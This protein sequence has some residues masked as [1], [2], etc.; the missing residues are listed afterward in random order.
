[1]DIIALI[2]PLVEKI[3]EERK[4]LI[5]NPESLSEFETEVHKSFDEAARKFM[6]KTLEDLDKGI[7]EHNYRKAHYNIQR[8]DSRTLITTVGDVTFNRTL[9]MNRESGK[10]RYL[11]DDMLRLD[12]HERFSEPAEA[13]MLA[14]AVKTSYREAA[15]V[16]PTKSEI[17]KTTVMNKVHSLTEWLPEETADEKKKVEYLLIDADEDHIAEQ[18]GRG[19]KGKN[20]SFMSRIL[21]VYTGK[22][23][24]CVGRKKLKDVHYI[25]GLYPGRDGIE[26]IWKEAWEYIKKN[27]DTKVL[28]KIYVCGDGAEW[29][30]SCR[31][32]LPLSEF[33]LDKFHLM[34]HIHEATGWMLDS[35]EDAR[36]DL[37]EMIVGNRMKRFTEYAELIISK[38]PNP[39][40]AEAMKTYVINNWE[41]IQTAYHDEN[42]EGCSA[43][44]HVS[45]V[46]SSRM[47]TRPM[48]WSQEGADSMSRLRCY[49][50]NG[51]KII[52]L[53]KYNR[54]KSR[55]RLK[56]TGTDDAEAVEA[57]TRIDVGVHSS[58]DIDASYIDRIQATIPGIT[59]I[60]AYCISKHLRL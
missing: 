43:E 60:K 34:K 11:L 22:E 54:E 58:Y 32:Y 4:K 25:G 3:F 16:L 14:E 28:T 2:T 51:G 48:G 8:H 24:E 21:Y 26:K 18:H 40:P 47:S 30:K 9:F 36:R 31:E 19:S 35:A 52:D 45:H 23:K 7:S 42:C 33:V 37:Y 53:V 10:C 20:G 12:A 29:I 39:I 17:T 27:Y 6:V 38:A 46:F 41:A 1:M 13:A 57:R 55:E 59:A 15:S 50:K 44:G 56:K 5:E 49:H